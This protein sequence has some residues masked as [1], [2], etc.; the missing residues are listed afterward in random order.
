LS[1]EDHS[2]KAD[3]PDGVSGRKVDYIGEPLLVGLKPEL[4]R[5][6]E[7][8]ESVFSALPPGGVLQSYFD[9]FGIAVIDLPEAQISWQ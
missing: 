7:S 2:G 4:V 9:R 5:D 3:A 1:V 6:P 8:R